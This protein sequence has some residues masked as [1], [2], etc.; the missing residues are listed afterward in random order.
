MLDVVLGFAA[1]PAWVAGPT[2]CPLGTAQ[3]EFCVDPA[4][5]CLPS[6]YVG[7]NAKPNCPCADYLLFGSCFPG[8][9][10][11]HAGGHVAA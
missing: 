3:D 11:D 1:V 8:V 6:L 5:H 4:V 2:P 7:P 10:G 9:G